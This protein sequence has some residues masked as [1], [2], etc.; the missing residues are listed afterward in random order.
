MDREGRTALHFAAGY[1][2]DT[3]VEMLLMV[4]DKDIANTQ[5]A[6]GQT[7]LQFAARGKQSGGNYEVVTNMLIER[8]S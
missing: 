3:V 5:D 6:H 7:A 1:G 2:S 8:G 4:V